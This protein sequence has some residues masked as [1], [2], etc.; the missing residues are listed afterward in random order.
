MMA[1]D[2]QRAYRHKDANTVLLDKDTQTHQ[3]TKTPSLRGATR[4]KGIW[5]TEV[6]QQRSFIS[7]SKFLVCGLLFCLKFC[8]LSEEKHLDSQPVLALALVLQ[9]WT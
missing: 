5:K 3:W 7:L 1:P 8:G 4:F 6:R 9:M 2:W